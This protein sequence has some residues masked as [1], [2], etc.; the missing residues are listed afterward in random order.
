[1]VIFEKL[2]LLDKGSLQTLSIIDRFK[3]WTTKFTILKRS[4]LVNLMWNKPH[5]ITLRHDDADTLK[6]FLLNFAPRITVKISI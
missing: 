5:K 6:K 1:M 4:Q 3:V 2:I